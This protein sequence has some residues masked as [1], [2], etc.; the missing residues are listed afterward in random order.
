MK[1]FKEKYSQISIAD[2]KDFLKE[3]FKTRD[4]LP[5]NYTYKNKEYTLFKD[6]HCMLLRDNLKKLNYDLLNSESINQLVMKKE[7]Q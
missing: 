5:E 3:I 2:D 4:T 1:I 6:K 7:K